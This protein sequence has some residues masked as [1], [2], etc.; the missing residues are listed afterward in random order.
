MFDMR[1]RK[2]I[3]LL[4]GAA[5]AWPLAARAQQPAKPVVGI[6]H[7]ASPDTLAHLAWAVREGLQEAGYVEGQNVAI[8]Y[9]W[10]HGSYDQLAA[11]AADLVRRQVTVI[12]A[13]GNVA[14]LAVKKAT[15]TIPI[16]FTSG[17]DPVKSGLVASLSRPEGN[18]TGVSLLAVEM[19]TKRLELIR[20]LLPHAR[21]VA[22]IVNP[23]YSGAESEMAD[24]EA[25]GRTIEIKAHKMTAGNALDIDTAFEAIGGLHVD[26]FM[27]GTDGFFITRRR[28]LAALAARHAIPGVYP[29]PDFPAAGGLLSYGVSL[30]DAYRQAGVYAGRILKGS[31]PADLPITQPTKFEFVINVWTAKALGLTIPPSFHLRADK[32]ID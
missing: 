22:M 2:F 31:K 32:V 15:A 3:T 8:E 9:R 18:L 20:D 23:D 19:A 30:M 14:A 10:A 4:G 28:Q 27:V 17:A 16:V 6:L 25:A 11:L 29:F 1:R 26:A 21:A 5:A 13:G 7:Y 24:V 12:V